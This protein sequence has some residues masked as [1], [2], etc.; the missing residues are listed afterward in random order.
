MGWN[1]KFFQTARG[2]YP[3]KEF[4]EE[5]D[6][7]TQAKALH[8]VRLLAINGPYLKPPYVK[9]LRDK[10]YELRIS[11]KVAVRIL[12][13]MIRNEYYLLH[14]FKKQSQKTPERELK[15]AVDRTKEMI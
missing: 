1:V 8:L 2:A 10:I 14:A 5:Q 11:G 3:V 12:Y 15:T 9:K 6:E 7:A 4:L 13:L